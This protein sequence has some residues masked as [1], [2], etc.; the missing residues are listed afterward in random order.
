MIFWSFDSGLLFWATLYIYLPPAKPWLALTEPL[1][2]AEPRLIAAGVNKDGDLSA[3]RDNYN[4]KSH[5]YVCIT[6]Y[7]DTNSN[8][9]PKP[10]TEPRNSEHSS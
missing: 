5:K 6:T 2:S 1:G 7:Q 3:V 10:T 4:L 9:N 8:P